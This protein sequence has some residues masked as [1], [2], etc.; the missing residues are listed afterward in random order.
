MG[1]KIKPLVLHVDFLLAEIFLMIN[2]Q[3]YEKSF[4]DILQEIFS[5]FYDEQSGKY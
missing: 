2:L 4:A 3:R 1:Y 5:E